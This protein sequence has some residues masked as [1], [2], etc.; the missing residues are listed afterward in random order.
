MNVPTD[1]ALP[2][3]SSGSSIALPSERIVQFA[4]LLREHGFQIGPG[5]QA[6]M[7]RA[8]QWLAGRGA[9]AVSA[10]WRA[11]TC[12]GPAQWREWPEL[13]ERFWFRHRLRGRVSISGQTRPRRSLRESVEDLHR[14]MDTP[15]D[16][17]PASPR[18]GQTAYSS[19]LANSG[20]EEPGALPRGQGGASRVEA[21]PNRDAQ[22][23]LPRELGELGRLAT[24]I[25]DRL[26][27]RPTRRW[28]VA[29]RGDR[30]DFRQTF[31][32]SLS[33]AADS[34]VPVWRKPRTVPPRIVIAVDVSRSM[35][36][37]AAFFLRVARAFARHAGA[38]VYV[39]HTRIAAIGPLLMRDS[40]RIQEK[41]NALAAGFGGG[42][43]IAASL[44]A[45]LHGNNR[46]ASP[47]LTRL[48][49]MS[50]GF[51]TDD[52]LALEAV[53]KRL[54]GR[55]VRLAWFYPTQ[56]KPTAQSFR[57]AEHHVERCLRLAD[58]PDL[59]ALKGCVR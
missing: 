11:L 51:D 48:W 45:L 54:R 12:R 5:E 19:A 22:C 41:I 33:C 47:R 15:S 27:P 34:L 32:R 57:A 9:V 7:L 3:G 8:A 30:L 38:G 29:S 50:D 23:W 16:L 18:Q 39:F 40:D 42:T 49:I 14:S 21:L 36:A 20:G 56:T 25:R 46:L 28:R 58:L 44:S 35:E 2:A 4:M 52:A 43:R 26:R 59:R 6:A 55:G 10:A 1:S 37:H 24:Q 13:F 31:R 53:L 17:P